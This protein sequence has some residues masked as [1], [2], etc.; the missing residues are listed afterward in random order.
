MVIL[1]VLIFLLMLPNDLIA[2]DQMKS[3]DNKKNINYSVNRNPYPVSTT[4][5]VWKNL[6]SFYASV[7]SPVDG[8]RSPSYPTGSAYGKIA[9]TEHGFFLGVILTADRL[10]HESDLPLTPV[11]NIYG[12]NRFYDPLEFNTFWWAD[13]KS[14][15]R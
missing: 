1:T 6:M 10:I 14:I 8:A 13:S 4:L 11:I 9:I 15:L 3:P 12:Q 7:I 2:E 5:F